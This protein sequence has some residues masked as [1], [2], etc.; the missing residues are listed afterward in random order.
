[1]LSEKGNYAW[2]LWRPYKC[3]KRRS[4]TFLYSIDWYNDNEEKEI[5]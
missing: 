2:A 3:C 5:Q 1:M 4:Q